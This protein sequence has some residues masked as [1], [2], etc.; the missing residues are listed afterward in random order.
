M[1]SITIKNRQ[2]YYQGSYD[3]DIKS[4]WC[5]KKIKRK[6]HEGKQTKRNLQAVQAFCPR[7]KPDNAMPLRP[8]KVG[9]IG[10]KGHCPSFTPRLL[11]K[12]SNRHQEFANELCLTWK[13]QQH[14]FFSATFCNKLNVRHFSAQIMHMKL[15]SLS[16]TDTVCSLVQI[17]DWLMCK[18]YHCTTGEGGETQLY[19][20]SYNGLYADI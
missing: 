2:T 18:P 17:P 9:T 5:F 13:K 4:A 19:S 11:V 15:T 3:S 14:N 6:R 7:D 10:C 12:G 8:S 16:G 1:Y 20:L